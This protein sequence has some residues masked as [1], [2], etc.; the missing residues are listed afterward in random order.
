MTRHPA[1]EPNRP[2][3][4]GKWELTA[5]LA[6]EAA[7]GRVQRAVAEW[8]SY[9]LAELL[10][11]AI[12]E[13]DELCDELIDVMELTYSIFEPN[14]PIRDR[15][16]VLVA[17]WEVACEVALRFEPGDEYVLGLDEI[18]DRAGLDG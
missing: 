11:A 7:A 4:H 5:E 13:I 17:Q 6:S 9:S 1:R 3:P 12:D 14:T 10:T 15:V 2:R 18:R 16:A 8:Q